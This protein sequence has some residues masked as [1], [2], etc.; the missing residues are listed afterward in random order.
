MEALE[1][2]Y[3]EK[4]KLATEELEKKRESETA[5]LRLEVERLKHYAA[6]SDASTP[7]KPPRMPTSEPSAKQCPDLD[8]DPSYNLMRSI[9]FEPIAAQPGVLKAGK[10]SPSTQPS[11]ATSL[12]DEACRD[13]VAS[14]S[15]LSLQQYGCEDV[16]ESFVVIEPIPRLLEASTCEHDQFDIRYVSAHL[17]Q[18]QVDQPL[19]PV[20]HEHEIHVPEESVDPGTGERCQSAIDIVD[21]TVESLLDNVVYSRSV[22]ET[23]L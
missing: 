18:F 22:P 6:A 8:S 12:H 11:F 4:L 10:G 20:D 23:T 13:M 21:S 17:E 2:G 16:D 9:A 5:Q 3:E 1:K 7:P 15:K 19:Q 14:S